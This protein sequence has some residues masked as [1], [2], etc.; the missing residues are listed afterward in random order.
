MLIESNIF[1]ILFEF[2]ENN[3]MKEKS[4]SRSD[5]L[6][7]LPRSVSHFN[8]SYLSVCLLAPRHRIDPGTNN[9]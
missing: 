9:N 8:F 2:I 4:E 6:V 7:S 3:E 1:D 5:P